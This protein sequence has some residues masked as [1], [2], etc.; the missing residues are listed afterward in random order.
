MV[1]SSGQKQW[2]KAVVKSSGQ[3]Q[4]SKAVVGLGGH[5]H[6]PMRAPVCF[7]RAPVCMTGLL[8]PYCPIRLTAVL[9]DPFDRRLTDSLTV[10]LT[11]LFDRRFD[12]FV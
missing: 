12:R 3:K 10:D 2:S 5:H 7:D 1:K 4:R 9:T 8:R 11:G 6:I